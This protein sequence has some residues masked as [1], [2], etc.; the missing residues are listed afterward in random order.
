MIVG[1]KGLPSTYNKDLQESQECMFDTYDNM[2][3]LLKVACG[4]MATLDVS[5][6]YVIVQYTLLNS[7]RRAGFTTKLISSASF[8]AFLKILRDTVVR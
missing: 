3:G 6:S 1:L 5:F 7:F 2:Q 8:L 4:V